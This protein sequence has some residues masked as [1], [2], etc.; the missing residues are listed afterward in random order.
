MTPR[1]NNKRSAGFT[2]VE[3]MVGLVI[4]LLATVVIMKVLSVFE[5]QKRTTT[6]TADAQINGNIALYNLEREVQMAGFPLMPYGQP[7]V[8]DS[9]LE[10]ATLNINGTLDATVP[11]RLSPLAI[12][13][14][15]VNGSD[16]ITIR[17]G[18]SASGG[19]FAQVGGAGAAASVGSPAPAMDVPVT[20]SLGC[21]N[22]D[23]ALFVMGGTCAMA[24]LSA[25]SGV[26][27][28]TTIT[29]VNNA[30]VTAGAAVPNANMA[31][32]GTWHEV[33]YRINGGNLERCDL[34]VATKNGGNCNLVTPN[35]NFV[36]VVAGI[37]NIQ[38]QY[39]IA[40]TGLL[41]SAANFNQVTQWVDATGAWA[42]PSAANRNLIKAV[43]V[44]VV[45]RN[46]RR[47]TNIV[48]T[49]VASWTGSASSPAPAVN[50]SATAA[51][52]N[53]YRYRVFD[54][55]IPLRNVIWSKSTL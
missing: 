30:A 33:T 42:T 26:P 10:C 1:L 7:G 13:D 50:L 55:I 44:A 2:L 5:A 43:R 15:G 22:S 32:L 53:H 16:T 48:T 41:S 6:G 39:G 49:G 31:C 38:A 23:A 35:A 9:P 27:N 25:T 47:E 29:L 52:W 20:D 46:A 11:N 21:N 40:A 54:T 12:T 24:P 18:D 14:G 28:A 45:A 51:D 4:G 36:P 3:I 19:I 17:Y 37:V 8:A 34:P